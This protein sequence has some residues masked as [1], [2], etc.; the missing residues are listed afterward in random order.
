MNK[1]NTPKKKNT[2]I[3]VKSA[4]KRPKYNNIICPKGM[5]LE[6][7]QRALRAQQAESETFGIEAL[8][9]G[10]YSVKNSATRSA[11]KVVFRGEG[12]P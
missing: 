11:Y 7:W 8:E 2:T 10:A 5:T 4:A 1:T 12:S 6:E 9:D 3:K